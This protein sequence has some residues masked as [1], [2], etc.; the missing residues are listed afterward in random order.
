MLLNKSTV[1]RF[2]ARGKTVVH[3]GPNKRVPC[4]SPTRSIHQLT[5]MWVGRGVAEE[6]FSVNEIYDVLPFI[7][8]ML[9]KGC[10]LYWNGEWAG[11]F[12]CKLRDYLEAKGCLRT[13]FP[14]SKFLQCL[15]LT[16]RFLRPE[17]TRC[18]SYTTPFI[19]F[20]VPYSDCLVDIW[21][22]SLG[23]WPGARELRSR[24]QW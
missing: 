20:P 19:Q 22:E 15:G 18:T 16:P 24:T 7:T 8:K 21:N 10:I 3:T 1:S 17:T 12:Y 13:Y 11:Y 5:R 6:M 4:C 14:L 9:G 2:L 23:L